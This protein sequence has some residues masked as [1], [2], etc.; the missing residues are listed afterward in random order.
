MLRCGEG[1]AA[2][3]LSSGPAPLAAA[4][5]D[6]PSSSVS[7]PGGRGKVGRIIVY[8]CQANAAAIHKAALR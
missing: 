8:Y 4:V 2:A 3:V 6:R 1:E 7:I 5:A